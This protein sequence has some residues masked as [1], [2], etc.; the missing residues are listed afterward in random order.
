MYKA[1]G[2]KITSWSSLPIQP[3]LSDIVYDATE[4]N[5]KAWI[6]DVAENRKG[7]PVIVYSRFP[8]DSNHVYYYAER[9]IHYTDYKSSIKMNVK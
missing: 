9:Y 7:D 1:N 8:N 6:W 2:E 5:E 4:T 3:R